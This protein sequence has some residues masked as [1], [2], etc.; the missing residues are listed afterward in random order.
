MRASTNAV[1][2]K[3]QASLHADATHWAGGKN[4]IHSICEGRRKSQY[5][6]VL[7]AAIFI[8]EET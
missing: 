2:L 7:A 3:H 6:V 4:K 1:L 5:T 8:Y